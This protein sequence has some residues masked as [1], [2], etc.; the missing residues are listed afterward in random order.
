MYCSE[1]PKVWLSGTIPNRASFI[2]DASFQ[3][4]LGCRDFSASLGRIVVSGFFW[5]DGNMV[6]E[7]KKTSLVV[8]LGS[9]RSGTSVMTKM[10]EVYG[11]HLG[12]SLLAGD[13]KSNPFG[14]FENLDIFEFNEKLLVKAG[15]S[16]LEPKPGDN[17][18]ALREHISEIRQEI[19]RLIDIEVFQKHINAIKEPRIPLLLEFWG[20][21]LS[22]P[23]LDVKVIVAM[24]HPNEVISSLAKRDHLNPILSLHLWLQSTINSIRF[25][26]HFKNCFVFYQELIDDPIQ[27]IKRVAGCFGFNVQDNL[28]GFLEEN[29]RNE[30]MH[31]KAD[32][33]TRS[34]LSV[35]DEVFEYVIKFR[36]AQ[37]TDFPDSLLDRWQSKL[38][39]T[40]NEID[41]N[42]LRAFDT[43][44]RDELT[45]QRDELIRELGLITGSKSW[46]M[47]APLRA[48][49]R[50]LRKLIG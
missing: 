10:L 18:Q 44:E 6:T 29:F 38:D 1:I 47:T 28:S 21:E 20:P 50:S 4:G 19:K 40:L 9:H 23:D 33:N 12:N 13:P 26:K 22:R 48:L 17:F 36:A 7:H 27:E 35:A 46:R 39:R 43:C 2:L 16:W 49:V 45:Q 11:C 15:T 41:V 37:E 32:L 14:H 42:I 30:F 5:F 8:V 24:R 25:A 31:H 34:P 3:A